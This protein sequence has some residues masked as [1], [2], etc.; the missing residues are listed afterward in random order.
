MSPQEV[1]ERQS[2]AYGM[3][4]ELAQRLRS[5]GNPL[6]TVADHSYAS[7]MDD[8]DFTTQVHLDDAPSYNW[9]IIH[10]LAQF[11]VGNRL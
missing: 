1:L 5:E 10:G 6:F 9:G 4:F 3:G 8:I 11:E 7:R 2:N